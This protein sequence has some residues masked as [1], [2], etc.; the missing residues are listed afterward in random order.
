[1]AYVIP[2]TDA[3]RIWDKVRPSSVETPSRLAALPCLTFAFAVIAC[4]DWTGRDYRLPVRL[5]TVALG[6]LFLPVS[7]ML[8]EDLILPLFWLNW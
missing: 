3:L 5:F 2:V 7:V 6:D 1:M 8:V 4:L